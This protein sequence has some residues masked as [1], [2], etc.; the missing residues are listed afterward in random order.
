MKHTLKTTCLEDI[1]TKTGILAAQY[2]LG[3]IERVTIASQRRRQ[4]AEQCRQLQ[5]LRGMV[6]LYRLLVN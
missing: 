5:A 3:P 4:G 6:A 1:R 2:N